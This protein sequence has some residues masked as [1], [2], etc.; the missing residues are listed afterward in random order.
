MSMRATV[1]DK[2]RPLPVQGGQADQ[3]VVGISLW[4]TAVCDSAC[5]LSWR[6]PQR[7]AHPPVASPICSISLGRHSF[8]K[9]GSSGL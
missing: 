4:L 5:A 8:V 9:N 2:R 6:G 7:S 1:S 3:K